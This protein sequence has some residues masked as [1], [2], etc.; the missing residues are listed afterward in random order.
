MIIRLA[1]VLTSVIMIQSAAMP[2]AVAATPTA[3]AAMPIVNTE[4][5]T[6]NVGIIYAN[7]NNIS[8]NA[9]TP[10]ANV[11]AQT[12]DTTKST[13]N[14][15]REGRPKVALV[16]GGG[17]AKGA[18]LVGVLKY[19]EQVG[20]PIDMIVG[21]SIGSIVGGLYSV[22]YRS[23]QMD[24][25][26][27]S[28]EW[29]DL[30]TDRNEKESRRLISRK[31]GVQYIMGI[32]LGRGDTVRYARQGIMMGDSIVAFL[33]SLMNTPD[34][35][36][37]DSLPIPFRCVAVDVKSMTEVVADCGSLPM[38]MRASMAIPVAF[39]PVQKD[40]MILVDGGVLN[41]LPVDVAREMGAD[42]VVAVD[43]TQNKHPDWNPKKVPE[44]LEG[45]RFL[46]WLLRRPD[47][48]KYNANVK[49]ADVYINPKLDNCSATSFNKVDYMIQQGEKAGKMAV[50]KLK[51]LK[52]YVESGK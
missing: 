34:S 40:S 14:T 23:A 47:R 33:D 18:S 8:A 5:S 11:E 31:N 49:A 16:L 46:S 42:F 52:K 1:F 26:F 6:I 38:A 15:K 39:K 13:I 36:S 21:T 37:F 25:L 12:A 30:L 20:L 43:L 45:T 4:N 24:T 44:F 9:G 32:P 27:R 7:A 28:Q 51:R 3:I 29:H 50:P 35:L 10:I 2:I 19:V 41:N 22:G 48:S 17:G